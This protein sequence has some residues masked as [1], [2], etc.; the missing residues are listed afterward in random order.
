VSEKST[1]IIGAGIA[2]LSA[3]CYGQMNGYK[4]RIFE[5]HTAPGGCCT[6]WER[7]GYKIDGCLHW[8]TGSHPGNVFYPLWEELGALPGPTIVD[9]E[10][11]ARIEGVDGQV[12][13]VYT[14]INR[15]K[16]HMHELA[17]EDTEFIKDFANGIRTMIHFPMPIEKPRELYGP[18]DGLK[19]MRRM[20]PYFGFLRKWGKVTIQDFARR[21]KNP[22]LRQVVPLAV[23]LQNGP[24]FPMLGF[25]MS[26]AWMDQKVAGYPIGGSLEFARTLEE[27]YLALGGQIHYGAAVSKI[28]VEADPLGRGDRVVGVRLA[29]GTEHCSD[30]VISA[31]DGRTTIFDMLDGRYI[32]NKIRGYYDRLPPSRPVIYIALGVA[33]SF[34]EM[35]HQTTGLDFPLDEPVRIG[36]RQRERLC[37]QVYNFDPSLAPAGKTVMRVYFATDYAYWKKLR[38]DPERYEAEKEQIADQV[39]A[40]LDRRFPG[41]AAQ[42]EMRDV[43]TPITFERYT[44]NWL[45]TFLGWRITTRTLRLRMGKTLPGLKNFYMAGQ[46]V[47]P[48]GGVPTAALSGRDVIQIICKGDKKEFVAG[49]P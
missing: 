38:Q 34:D 20:R 33:R 4:T 6:T 46:W 10:E 31:A 43:A 19:V 15:L 23:N 35:P 22:F 40:A 37:V 49:T 30:H 26:L 1:I 29:D 3:G 42:V 14:D 36:D 25:L 11:Y 9:H 24:D 32:S 2:G 5:M 44:G 27:R 41:L 21:F 17:P 45:G 16:G 28:L 18:I 7:E 48:G 8:L 13:V 47:E 12:F 39:V